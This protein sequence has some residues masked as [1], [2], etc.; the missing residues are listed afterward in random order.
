MPVA[1][2]L[3]TIN[4]S[5]EKLSEKKAQEFHHV[6]AK[7][8][9]LCRHTHQDIQMA[10]TFLCTRGKNPDTDDYKKLSCMIQ[11][12]RGMQDLTL[13]IEHGEHPR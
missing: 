11:Y 8:L 10:V 4:E 1:G 2:H 13:M 6:V 5:C 3:F 12:L 7:L 9:Y